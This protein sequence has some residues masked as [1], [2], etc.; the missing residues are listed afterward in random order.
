LYELR[1]ATSLASLWRAQGRVTDARTLLA[2]TT[3]WFTEGLDTADL[4]TARHLLSEL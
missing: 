1:A 4:L 2:A 3:G